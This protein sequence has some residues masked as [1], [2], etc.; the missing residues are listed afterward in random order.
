MLDK[1]IDVGDT[2]R[3]L[4]I[5][6]LYSIYVKVVPGSKLELCISLHCARYVSSSQR[7]GWLSR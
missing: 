1:N 5:S 3:I 6:R 2:C 7:D 4:I